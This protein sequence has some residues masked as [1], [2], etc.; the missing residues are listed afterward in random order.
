MRTNL[1]IT[2]QEYVLRDGATIVSRTDL[3]GRI[4]YVNDEFIEASG[5]TESELIG[6]PHNILRHPDMPEEAF[7]D[8]WRTLQAGRPWTGMVKNRRKNGDHYWVVANATPLLEGTS[9]VGFMSVRTRAP[10]EQVEAA[11]ALYRRFKE[12]K[13]QGWAIVEGQ[14]VKQGWLDRVNVVGPAWERASIPA[15]FAALG[16]LAGVA[17][18]S[19][20]FAAQQGGGLWWAA[21][22]VSGLVTLLTGS[23]L[24]SLL[25]GSLRRREEPR[26]IRTGPLR[27]P[28]ARPW[29]R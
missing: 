8:M 23:R 14:G 1:P 13:A 9:T 5:F 26:A 18:A 17:A 7:A 20:A 15:K 4:T 22:A 24:A 28:G 25:G 2:Q 27:C 10:R 21:P 29:P 12:G 11:E 19:S 6:Q 3:K 16:A